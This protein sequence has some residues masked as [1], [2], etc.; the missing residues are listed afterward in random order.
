MRGLILVLRLR[1]SKGGVVRRPP[2]SILRGS[3]YR[4]VIFY[5]LFEWI[6]LYEWRITSR[7]W[8]VVLELGAHA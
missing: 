7:V 1:L 3:G 4:N 5:V 8:A 2:E 6:N